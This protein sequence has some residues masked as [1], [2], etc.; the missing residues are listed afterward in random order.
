MAAKI[1]V[2]HWN[3]E[4]SK[5][6][7]HWSADTIGALTTDI[8]AFRRRAAAGRLKVHVPGSLAYGNA[9]IIN[10]LKIERF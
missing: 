6:L 9:E 7:Q 5:C 8:Q 2:E 4:M 10:A 3:T 1:L